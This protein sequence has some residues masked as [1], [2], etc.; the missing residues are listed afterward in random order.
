MDAASGGF[1]FEMWRAEGEGDGL[2]SQLQDDAW[3]EL[4]WEPEL[5]AC[6]DRLVVDVTGS[7][8]TLS[9]TVWCYP[10]KAVAERAA[11]RVPGVV[12]VTNRIRVEL[13]PADVRTD[14][15]IE[16]E[17]RRVL[18]WDAL[19]PQDRI[20][21]GVRDGTVTLSGA[22]DR[23]HQRTAAE[24]AVEPLVGLTG[25]VNRITVRP[26]HVTGELQ[27]KVVAAIRR[28][29]AKHVRVET[30]G[31]VVELRGRVPS[32]AERNQIEHAVRDIP[33]VTSVE[34]GLRIQR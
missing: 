31:G 18:G 3:E 9:G 11:C 6:C 17:V 26:M 30:H 2:A 33:G 25:V 28:V 16:E 1:S 19:V 20:D 32:I 23:E 13:N 5:E 27:A 24:T 14:P 4:R 22:V 8:V 7:Q 10:Q 21:V 12:A 34:D 29:R 15:S